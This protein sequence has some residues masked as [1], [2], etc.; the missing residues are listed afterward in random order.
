MKISSRDQ[1]S[2]YQ[3]LGLENV[4]VKGHKFSILRRVGSANLMYN[5]MV[6]IANSI[7]HTSNLLKVDCKY[8]HCN[9]QEKTT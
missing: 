5:V 7:S 3:E 6:L 4:F 8:P 9:H 2:G 1:N